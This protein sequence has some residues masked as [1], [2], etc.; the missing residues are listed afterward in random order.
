VINPSND[1]VTNLLRGHILMPQEIRYGLGRNPYYI[2]DS[3]RAE[4]ILHLVLN[5]VVY[6]DIL[7]IPNVP[8]ILGIQG[9]SGVGKSWQ[10]VAVCAEVDKPV[11]R[12]S[13]ASLSGE[14]ERESAAVLLESYR[15]AAERN[16]VV[17]I[18][19]IDT[20]AASN[21]GNMTTYTVNRQLLCGALMNLSDMPTHLEGVEGIV[22]RTPIIATGNDFTRIYQ[23]LRRH[24]RMTLYEYSPT[25][26][27]TAR[28]AFEL[29]KNH[30]PNMMEP[31]IEKLLNNGAPRKL[32]DKDAQSDSCGQNISFVVALCAYAYR[33]VVWKL[34]ADSLV[35]RPHLPQLLDLI[36][37][38]RVE[39][40]RS[41]A[42]LNID[43]LQALACQLHV[44][45][46]PM[47][48]IDEETV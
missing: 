12:I 10:A 1:N 15:F 44:K 4:V 26:P 3:F 5:E 39:V 17:L 27:E 33:A 47:R 42:A 7:P 34:L 48:Y 14:F 32:P 23:P 24:G 2:P 41:L 40:S 22:R 36:K 11:Y 8:L 30:F 9:P 35:D 46:K 20:S 16:C 37:S 21:F 13:G 25:A 6:R 19:D 38:Q 43:D 18:E 31:D 28:K 45:H 29:L